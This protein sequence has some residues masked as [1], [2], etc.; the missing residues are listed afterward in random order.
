MEFDGRTIL[1]SG[2]GRANG[3]GA[4]EA[5]HLVAAGARVL[6][7]DICDEGRDVASDLGERCR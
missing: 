1:I 5:R 6:I 7:G 4:A 2:A 3:Q